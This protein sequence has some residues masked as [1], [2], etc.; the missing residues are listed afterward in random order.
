MKLRKADLQ[1][2]G[3]ASPS[4]P[5]STSTQLQ[6]HPFQVRTLLKY[7]TERLGRCLFLWRLNTM[8]GATRSNGEDS[9]V[10]GLSD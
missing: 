3:E 2:F 7:Y 1:I 9:S 5:D 6:I 4:F 10:R 8:N